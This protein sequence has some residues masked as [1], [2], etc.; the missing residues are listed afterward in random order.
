MFPIAQAAS[1]GGGLAFQALGA[2]ESYQAQ[3]G[4]YQS[5]KNIAQLEQQANEQNWDLAQLNFRR[6]Q[7]ESLRRAQQTRSIAEASAVGSG[8]QFGSGAKGAQ[9]GITA[10]EERNLLGISQNW[11]IG[12]KLFDINQSISGQKIAAANYQEKASM[13][14]GL[15]SLGG[16]LASSSQNLGQLF[17]NKIF[18]F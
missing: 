10:D 9:A 18:G 16:N 11:Q 17:P 14:G 8:A 13:W 2:Y 5:Q 3:Q 15:G 6:S 12:A 1:L 4:Y 7:L